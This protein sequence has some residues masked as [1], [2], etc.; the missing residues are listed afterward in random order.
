MKLIQFTTFQACLPNLFVLCPSSTLGQSC[1]IHCIYPSKV[2]FDFSRLIFFYIYFILLVNPKPLYFTFL[3][4]PLFPLLITHAM[5][6]WIVTFSL[7]N[8][9]LTSPHPSSTATFYS[10][11]MCCSGCQQVVGHGK[12]LFKPFLNRFSVLVL[13][14]YTVRQIDSQNL[15]RS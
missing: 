1:I 9:P 2:I 15:N 13:Y 5:Q 10:L 12:G 6:R 8:E 11:T 3:Q 14:R 4:F 7:N